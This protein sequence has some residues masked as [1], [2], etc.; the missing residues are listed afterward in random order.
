MSRIPLAGVVG[1][2][3]A[4]SLSPRL[5]GHWL[6]RYGLPGHYV[7]LDVTPDDLAQVLATLPR[8]GFVGVNVTIPHKQAALALATQATERAQ[9]I[10]AANTLTFL[11]GGGFAADNTD[12]YGFAANLVHGAP[13]FRAHGARALV[14]GAGGAARAVLDAL[15]QA[16]VARIGLANR[17][18]PRAE[19]LAADF[20][21]VIAVIDWD[22]AGEALETADLVVNTTSLGMTG[23]PPLPI[24][25]DR[26][27]PGQVVTDLVYT[28]L[29]TPLL[30]AAS[31]AGA[32]T[33]DGLGMLLHQAAPGFEDWFRRRPEVDAELRE[34]VL[35]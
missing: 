28:P 7:P 23:Q 15:V 21:P 17:T 4:H 25:L 31:A 29:Q 19:A 33:V 20:G 9:R 11:P 14:L 12:G 10:G 1:H 8:M 3:V 30:A 2:P 13:D 5:H 18:R 24:P 26:L 34:S 27:H 35:A 6:A 32:V 16:G 22:T